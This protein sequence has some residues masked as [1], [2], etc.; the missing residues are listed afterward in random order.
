MNAKL[1]KPDFSLVEREYTEKQSEEAKM[2]YV[3]MD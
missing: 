2:I 1:L 3:V